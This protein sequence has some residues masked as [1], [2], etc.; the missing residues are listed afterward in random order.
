[1]N[2][3]K[4]VRASITIPVDFVIY[5]CFKKLGLTSYK[6]KLYFVKLLIDLAN[7]NNYIYSDACRLSMLF[8]YENKD[9]CMVIHKTI[10]NKIRP[11]LKAYN[12]KNILE[13]KL[14]G[15]HYITIIYANIVKGDKNV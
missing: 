6:D 10:N 2:K 8:G 13:I 5:E 12:V 3:S 14:N 11:I 7:N 9:I 15:N 1:M 4:L